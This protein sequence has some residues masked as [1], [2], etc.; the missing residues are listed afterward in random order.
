M[1]ESFHFD[2]EHMTM[3][4]SV[5]LLWS[6]AVERD[7]NPQGQALCWCVLALEKEKRGPAVGGGR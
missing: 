6:I 1:V 3:V 7:A 4:W 5:L 2:L